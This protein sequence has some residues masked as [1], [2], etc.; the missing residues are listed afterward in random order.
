[1]MRDPSRIKARP[2]VPSRL[3]S[4]E[5]WLGDI[6]EGISEFPIGSQ[7]TRGIEIAR[8]VDEEYTNCRIDLATRDLGWVL[9]DAVLMGYYGRQTGVRCLNVQSTDCHDCPNC[10]GCARYA[11]WRR[12]YPGPGLVSSKARMCA[13]LNIHVPQFNDGVAKRLGIYSKEAF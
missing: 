4:W 8:Q 11:I 3:I 1:M 10:E 13:F 12:L 5:K 2:Y 9:V 6:L 7:V